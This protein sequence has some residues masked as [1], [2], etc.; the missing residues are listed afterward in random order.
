MQNFK[1]VVFYSAENHQG[2]WA[3][4]GEGDGSIHHHY[5]I[6][7][8]QLG[9]RTFYKN[10]PLV[11]QITKFYCQFLEIIL[12]SFLPARERSKVGTHTCV[13][14]VERFSQFE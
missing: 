9:L 3:E 2:G 14:T 5:P 7:W 13:H 8:I 12:G 6:L 4:G 11:A 1:L 10:K